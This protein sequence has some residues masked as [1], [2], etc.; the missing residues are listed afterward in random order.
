VAGRYRG[1]HGADVTVPEVLGPEVT[2]TMLV[3]ACAPET[4]QWCDLPREH[5]VGD[6]VVRLSGAEYQ[7]D[8]EE[9][10]AQYLASQEFADVVRLAQSFTID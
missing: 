9:E 3:P 5:A 7:F 4:G 6:V 10:R 2:L 8:S 1:K